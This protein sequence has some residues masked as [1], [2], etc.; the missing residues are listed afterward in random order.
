MKV[1]SIKLEIFK[2]LCSSVAEEMGVNN[3]AFI[4][5]TDNA[6]PKFRK[7]KPMRHS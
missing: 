2:S 6:I 5:V 3:N 7:L 1:D 4:F